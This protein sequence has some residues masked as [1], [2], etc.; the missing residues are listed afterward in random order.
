MTRAGFLAAALSTALAL[1]LAACSDDSGQGGSPAA[2]PPAAEPADSGTARVRHILIGFK[3]PRLKTSRSEEQALELSKSL[4]ADLAAG[5]RTF[6]EL[7]DAFTDDRDPD[8][9]PNAAPGMPP[10]TY[11]VYKTPPDPRRDFVKPFKDAAF[12][13]PVGQVAPE[14]VKSQFGYHIIRREK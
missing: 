6:D 14:P 10:G 8:G 5:R 11:V 13:T 2:T 12:A 4:I 7:V 1:S 9:K 3:G